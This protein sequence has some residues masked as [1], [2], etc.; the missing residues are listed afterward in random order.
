VPFLDFEQ[1]KNKDR[2]VRES[3]GTMIDMVQD[4]VSLVSMSAFLMAMAML[5]GAM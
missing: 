4:V 5:I 1:N 3:E 2:T